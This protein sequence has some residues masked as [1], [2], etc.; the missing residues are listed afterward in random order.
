[1]RAGVEKLILVDFDTVESSNLN[2]LFG[3]TSA[4]VGR[5][6]VQVVA[7]H[8]R[9]M[10]PLE[11]DTICD[12]VLKQSVLKRLRVA[13]LI[14]G[15]VDSDLARSV[16]ARFA[17]QYLTPLI[18]MG[19]RLDGRKGWVTAAA[20]RVSVVGADGACLRCSHH[21]NPERVRAESLPAAE[22][23]AL[24]R[25]GYI[26]GIDEPAPA[27]VTL[28]CAIAGLG[29]TAALNLFVNLTGSPQP[30]SQLYDA[31]AGIVFTATPVH[32]PGCDICDGEQGVKA[33]GDLQVV[34]AYD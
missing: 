1:V 30:A 6:K 27:V 9:S 33:L 34:S 19:I 4:S 16:L 10:R 26:M 11:I 17:Y 14:L 21:I 5:P 8:L 29:A 32:E 20:G 15:C 24:A 28:N 7:A 22:R 31:A 2:R 12:S 3:A 18:D 25:E 23:E 13:D